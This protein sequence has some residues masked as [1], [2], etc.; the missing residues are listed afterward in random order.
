MDNT[1]VK[2][3]SEVL[4]KYFVITDDKNNIVNGFAAYTG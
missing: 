3:K 2:S 4:E 1:L